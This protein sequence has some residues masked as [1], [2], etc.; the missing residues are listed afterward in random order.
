MKRILLT[1]LIIFFTKSIFSATKIKFATV[2]PDG[3]TWMKAMHS[4]NQELQQ[5]TSGRVKFIFFPGGIAGDEK[6]ILRKMRYGKIHATAV[7]GLGM[8]KI[9]PESRI[10]DLPFFFNNETEV[11]KIHDEM[12]D[13]FAKQFRDK[14]YE[15]ITWSEVGWT[16]LFSKV[17]ISDYNNY[18]K[19]KM[20]TWEG[21]QIALKTL[22]SLGM[23]PISLSVADVLTSL[24]T[25]LLDSIYTPPLAAI[26]MQWNTKVKY[27]LNTPLVHASGALLILSKQFKRLKAEDQNILLSLGQKH[28]LKLKIDARNENRA[29]LED[30]KSKGIHIIEPNDKLKNKFNEIA[31]EVQNHFIGKMYDKKLLDKI[32]QLFS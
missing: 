27:V 23:S 4:Y 5:K 32:R 21:D 8:G 16:Y 30:M 11:D 24:Q 17:D 20:W 28:I 31:L 1:I 15:L 14:G 2:A 13:Y 18:T 19:L 22:Q 6:D 25:G 10:L 26:A 29:A 12:F 9:L 7:T 3:T